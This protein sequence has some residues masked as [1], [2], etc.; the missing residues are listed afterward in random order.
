MTIT[1]RPEDEPRVAL[2][3]HPLTA[4]IGAE[5]RNV[6]LGAASRSDE[7]FTELKTLLLKHKV[8]FFR[9][10]HITRA[11]HVAL[12]ERFGPLEDHPVARQRSGPSGPGPHL[13]GPGQPARALRE[14]LSL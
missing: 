11:E 4:T 10:Q 7:L 1:T 3:V 13:Q 6:D 12:A 2:D 5:V 9:D 14:R 8:L